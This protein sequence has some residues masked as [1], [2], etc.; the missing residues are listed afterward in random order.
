MMKNIQVP[1]YIRIA[2]ILLAVVLVYNMLIVA[3]DILIPLVF[4]QL[5]AVL[6]YPLARFFEDRLKINRS[7][8][9]LLSVILFTLVLVCFSYFFI[10]QM[11]S[12]SED[13]PLLRSRFQELL[14]SIQRWFSF[15]FHVNQTQQ[16]NFIENSANNIMASAADYISN[17]FKSMA[18]LL[19]WVVFIFIYT[20]F[21]LFHRNI[22]V[23][24]ML[25]LF[26]EDNRNQVKEVIVETKGII[27]SYLGG[28]LIEMLIV[29]VVN[30]TMFFIMGIKYAMLLG[31]MAAVF[32]IIPYLGVYTS[33]VITLVITFA[34][35]TWNTAL[36][37]SAGLFIV[38]LI[39]SNFLMPRIVGGRVKMNSFITILA[40][41][42]GNMVWGIPGMFLF[43][44]VAG[45]MKMICERTPGLEAWAILMG[46]EE[47]PVKVKKLPVQK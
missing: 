10:A 31:I 43:I 45:I 8:S 42:I 44:P 23:K 13:F 5:V 34:N 32:N 40:V 22:L 16:I 46:V 47:K 39:D 33:I 24:F 2:A 27:N 18:T 21:V 7:F 11:V 17:V 37:A 38:H 28:L 26:S 25:Y 14:E 3:K 35:S 6:L 9:V 29:G 30:C 15:K 41:V 19:L 1:F 12:F 20:F 36:E 4:A